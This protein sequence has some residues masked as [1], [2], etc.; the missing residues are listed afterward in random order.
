[1]KSTRGRN[2]SFTICA[3]WRRQLMIDW[4]VARVSVQSIA[5]DFSFYGTCSKKIPYFYANLIQIDLVWN[6]DADRQI[7]TSR[8][9]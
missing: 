5:N 7:D 3:L 9:Q 1:M 4:S 6:V 8:L 2:Q